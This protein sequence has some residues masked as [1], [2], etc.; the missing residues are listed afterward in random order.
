MAYPDCHKAYILNCDASDV[1]ISF[2]LSQL[3][4]ENREVVIEYAGRT[5]RKSELNYSVTD[6]EALAVVEGFRKF[7]TYLYGNHTT[8]IT[9][10]Q[11]LEYVY[12]NPKITGRISRWNI[13][14][15][16]YDYTVQYKKGKHNTNADAISRLENL[17]QPDNDNADDII[18]ENVDLFVIDPDPQDV[19]DRE[20]QFHEY[21]VFEH[22]ESVIPSVMPVNDIDICIDSL[23]I[24]DNVSKID[25]EWSIFIDGFDNDIIDFELLI[26]IY[27]W[28]MSLILNEWLNDMSDY[29][30]FIWLNMYESFWMMDRMY[31]EFLDIMKVPQY[32]CHDFT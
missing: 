16:N 13:L 27:E 32:L 25:F 30:W 21:F 15:Q 24:R 2:I 18:P 26:S 17:P 31:A 3:N 29:E 1:A 8:V 10:H 6:K 9:D 23:S 12:K 4:D 11:A 5:L 19:I 22:M 7:H 14:L 28:L 20:P